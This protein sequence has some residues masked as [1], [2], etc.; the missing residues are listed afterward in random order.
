MEYNKVWLKKFEH[1]TA[2][3]HLGLLAY[4]QLGR[5]IFL[6]LVFVI[7]RQHLFTLVLEC[8]VLTCRFKLDF[9]ENVFW[10][11]SQATRDD[12]R[13]IRS[14]CFVKLPFRVKVAAQRSQRNLWKW[15]F[16][17]CWSSF[18]TDGKKRSQSGHLKRGLRWAAVTWRCR[19]ETAANVWKDKG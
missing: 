17:R 14:T 3:L 4:I 5:T 13:W 10:H 11:W 15:T 12:S 2:S 18:G 16:T 8:T 9:F 6:P 19:L 1:T 7:D